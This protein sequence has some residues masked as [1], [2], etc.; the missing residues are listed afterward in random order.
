MKIGRVCVKST[1][2]STVTDEENGYFFKEYIV[3]LDDKKMVKIYK[4]IAAQ[5]AWEKAIDIAYHEGEFYECSSYPD[6]DIKV[7]A[8]SDRRGS[9][10]QFNEKELNK[11]YKYMNSLSKRC[12]KELN[13]AW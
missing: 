5:D 6:A 4:K 10:F 11:S 7:R 13:V 9:N 12:L 8:T 1:S 2:I 3:D